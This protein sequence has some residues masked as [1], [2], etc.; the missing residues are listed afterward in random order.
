MDEP[1]EYR[2][3]GDIQQ[4]PS[5]RDTPP[6][7]AGYRA[8]LVVPV[9][10]DG[11][12]VA[13][14][15]VLSLTPDRYG[16]SDVVF[17]QRMATYVG[18]ALSHQR[19]ADEAARAAEVRERAAAL[20]RRVHQLSDE[21]ASLAPHHRAVGESAAWTRV[22]RLAT[23]V[24][25]SNTTVLLTGESGT[26][27]EVVARYVHRA[28]PRRDGPF[29]ALNC[30]A[31]PDQLLESELFGYE[32]GA[33]TGAAQAK[34]GHLE[35][36][37]GGTLLLDEIGDLSASAQVKLLR[38]LETREFQRL[39]GTRTLHAD[40]RLIAATNRDLRKAMAAGAFRDD[41]FYRLNVF[42]I[43]LAPLRDR[44]EDV[45]VLCDAF[46]EDLGRSFGRPPAGISRDARDALLAHDWPGNV[47]EL[48]N[49][50]ERAAILCDGGL[51]TAAHLSLDRRRDDPAV[52][53]SSDGDLASGG[54]AAPVDLWSVERELIKQALASARF[55][56]AKAARSLG[57]SRT[58]LYVRLRRYGLT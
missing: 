48:R 9:R 8:S 24:A 28:S 26:G 12:L 57:L 19:L 37:A 21:L 14:L 2:I 22:I 54:T 30:G 16:P 3:F 38:A 15:N 55:N 17:A 6:H 42:A 49:A 33:F 20:E 10:I 50:L 5:L 1:W 45:L 7:A 29:V 58:Q 43:P 13:V 36:A 39:G 31:V 47:R 41:L 25:P 40:V 56:K 27:K 32:R 23:Q 34:A 44:R 4:E 35:L 52:A 53:S 11:T 18:L 51:I 46:L